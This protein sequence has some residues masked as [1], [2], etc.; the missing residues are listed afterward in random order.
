MKKIISNE[1]LLLALRLVLG[2]IFIYAGAE[3]ISS[4]A[5]F[6][7]SISNYQLLNPFMINVTAILLPWLEVFSGI[8]LLSGAAVK[9]NSFILSGLLAVFI[10]TAVISLARGLDIDCGCFGTTTVR[11]GFTKILENTL[12]LIAGII[13]MIYGSD[14]MSVKNL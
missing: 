5:V 4:P 3:K 7:E 11:L 12:L 9:E 13:L 8:L 10:I 1:Y 6:T 14:K 2:F